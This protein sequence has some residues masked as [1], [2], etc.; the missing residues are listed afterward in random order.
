MHGETV[1]RAHDRAHHVVAIEMPG[2]PP[3]AFGF[4]HFFVADQIPRAGGQEAEGHDSVERVRV[5]GIARDLLF[6]EPGIGLIR[7]QGADDVIAI[8]PGVGS[9][10]ILVVAVRLAEMNDV[11]PMPRPAFAILR[12]REQ[13]IDQPLI[14]RGIRVGDERLDLGV[15]RWQAHEIEIEPAN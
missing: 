2:D 13:A 1:D 14:G 8:R 6:D 15:G 5:E 4:G 10:L 12:R 7:V 11:E 3:V 9:R